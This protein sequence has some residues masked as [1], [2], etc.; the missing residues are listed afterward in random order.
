MSKQYIRAN[1]DI[2]STNCLNCKKE[3]IKNNGKQIVYFCNKKCR[4][5]YKDKL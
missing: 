2:V 1:K 3:V 4:K 5:E